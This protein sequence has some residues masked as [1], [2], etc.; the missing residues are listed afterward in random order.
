MAAED[1][2]SDELGPPFLCQETLAHM[3]R[4]DLV[5]CS[6]EPLSENV[7]I[8]VKAAL[9]AS[10]AFYPATPALEEKTLGRHRQ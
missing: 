9:D 2:I 5:L 6:D 8:T 1:R 7:E 3:P 10:M 4:K